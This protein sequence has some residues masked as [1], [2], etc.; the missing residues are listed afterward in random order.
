MD[1]EGPSETRALLLDGGAVDD[2][3]D[4]FTDLNA[5]D[6]LQ[7]A[8]DNWSKENVD[9]LSNQMGQLTPG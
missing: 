6:H 4:V 9:Q 3:T 1:A 5:G 2:G 8:Q 7:A